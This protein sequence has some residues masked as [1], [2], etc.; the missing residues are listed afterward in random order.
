M[1][2]YYTLVGLTSASTVAERTLKMLPDASASILLALQAGTPAT[3]ALLQVT[4]SP[5][6]NIDAGTAVWVTPDNVTTT[7]TNFIWRSAGSE[8]SQLT[9]LRVTITDGTWS[10]QL[11][12]NS[13]RFGTG[14]SY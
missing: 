5:Y 3:G 6:E 1:E 9:G 12:Q 13:V 11:R 4:N 8:S 14:N 7:R 2:P 10:V